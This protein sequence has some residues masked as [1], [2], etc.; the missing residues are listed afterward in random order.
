MPEKP[1]RCPDC[2]RTIDDCYVPVDPETWPQAAVDAYDL[3][4]YSTAA[5]CPV[6]QIKDIRRTTHGKRPGFCIDR[7]VR[8]PGYSG[9]PLPGLQRD[10][11]GVAGRRVV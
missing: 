11:Q 3:A 4:G 2:R 6:G 5:T 10:V 9:P 7:I 8:M 1:Q